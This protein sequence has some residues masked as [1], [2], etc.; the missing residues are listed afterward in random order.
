MCV[1]GTQSDAVSV[2]GN[3][4]MCLKILQMYVAFYLAVSLQGI[5]TKELSWDRHKDLARK[6]AINSSK[7]AVS[8]VNVQ[9]LVVV[10]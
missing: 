8:S 3:P 4:E 9:Q 10:E 6:D 1:E 5:H 7:K 2:K